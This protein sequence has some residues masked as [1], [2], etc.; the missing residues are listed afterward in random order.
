M[1][2]LSICATKVA[3]VLRDTSGTR[4]KINYQ[5][6]DAI[7]MIHLKKNPEA[8]YKVGITACVFKSVQPT[9]PAKTNLEL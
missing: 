3:S 4:R 2:D 9:L 7:I 5:L 8:A 6:T 1:E